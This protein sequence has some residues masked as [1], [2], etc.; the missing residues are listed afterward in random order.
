MSQMPA[1]GAIVHHDYLSNDPA[2]SQKFY[3]KLFGWKFESWDPT[4][5]M[6]EG[7]AGTSGG[8]RKP[9]PGESVGS[10]NYVLVEDLDAKV[11]EAAAN[12][13]RILV[14]KQEVPNMGWLAVFLVPGGI[15]QG[16]WQPAPGP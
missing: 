12:G 3:G 7:P 8:F 4:Y 15:V 2:A 5:T 9:E 6:F 13:A 14:A 10:F 1:I 11:K 16:I